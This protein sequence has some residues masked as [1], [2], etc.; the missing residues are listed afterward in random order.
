MK[1]LLLISLGVLLGGCAFADT[2]LLEDRRCSSHQDCLS[3]GY[4]CVSGYCMRPED[5]CSSDE[6]CE[7]GSFCNG[8]ATCDPESTLADNA[9]C[10][11]GASPP[12]SDGVACTNDHCN[13]STR[14]VDHTPGPDCICEDMQDHAACARLA[15][16][17]GEVC[18]L[19]QCNDQLTCDFETAS[20]GTQCQDSCGDEQV[21][22]TCTLGECT[23]DCT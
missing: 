19:G 22:G 15:E 11:Q 1:K 7:D 21:T 8:I 6:D 17:R 16:A 12:L 10:V 2:D 13:E 3:R 14:S 18:T 9:G 4:S 23:I 20:D 5:A